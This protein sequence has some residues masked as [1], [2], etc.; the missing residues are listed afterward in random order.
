VNKKP[1]LKTEKALAIAMWDFSWLERRWSGAGYEDWDRAL[2]ELA[3]RGYNA[4]RVDAYPHLLATGPEKTWR[5][6]PQWTIHDWGACGTVDSVDFCNEWPWWA[7]FFDEDAKRFDR[8]S[9]DSLAWM[10]R[11]TEVLQRI[12]ESQFQPSIP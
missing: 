9:G 7:T 3:E 10:K 12:R 8:C 4:V 2:D 6:K 1:L 11:G 5:L